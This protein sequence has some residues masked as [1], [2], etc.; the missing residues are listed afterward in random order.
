MVSSY[1]IYFNLTG[2][3]KS[4]IPVKFLKLPKKRIS[5]SIMR[6]FLREGLHLMRQFVYLRNILTV[7][8]QTATD[9]LMSIWS[10]D[11][12]ISTKTLPESRTLYMKLISENG[13]HAQDRSSGQKQREDSERSINR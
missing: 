7:V 10:M 2:S 9:S 8:C 13:N 6:H 11:R 3:D 5:V 4:I 1:F 12:P